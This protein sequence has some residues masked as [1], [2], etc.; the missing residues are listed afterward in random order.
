[1]TKPTTEDRY[2]HMR[3][4][5]EAFV[6]SMQAMIASFEREGDEDMASRLKV[7][8]LSPWQAAIAAD[9]CGDLWTICVACGKPIKTDVEHV[10]AED[11]SFHRACVEHS[12]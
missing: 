7:W 9:D 2:Q 11:C 5:A 12:P 3:E 8:C 6:Q 10:A 1:M 4:N